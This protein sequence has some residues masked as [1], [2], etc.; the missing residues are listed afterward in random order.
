[1]CEQCGARLRSTYIRTHQ[2]RYCHGRQE[3]SQADEEGENEEENVEELDEILGE[4]N[5]ED[6]TLLAAG[7]G[8]VNEEDEDEALRLQEQLSRQRQQRDRTPPRP[9]VLQS[10]V[11]RQV[12]R[13]RAEE[14]GDDV[15]MEDLQRR[16][17]ALQR[18][19]PSQRRRLDQEEDHTQNAGMK[20]CKR[21]RLFNLA[22]RI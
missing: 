10:R 19:P 17:Q 13:D 2:L 8:G 6:Q 15:D 12:H 7:I 4:I 1:M 22:P 9:D 16:W 20:S 11:A 5:D 3:E 18:S 14:D 21:Y